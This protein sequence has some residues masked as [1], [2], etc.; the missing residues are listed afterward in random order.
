MRKITISTLLTL[1]YLAGTAQAL[2]A[3]QTTEDASLPAASVG[4]ERALTINEMRQQRGLTDTHN[5]F[6]PRGQWIFGGTASYSTHSN[7]T[8]RFLVVEGI[9]SK[10]YTF[11]VSPMI[12]YALRDNM[13]IGGRFIYSRSLLKLDKADLNL[14]GEDSDLNFEVNDYYSLRHSYSVAV[15]WRQYIPLGRNKRFALFNEMQLSGGG[16]QARFAKDSPVKGTYETGYTFSLG[17]SPGIV[18]FATNNMAVEVNVG[19]MGITYTH[20]KQ[21]HNQVTG[22]KRDASMMNFKVNIFSIGLG[23]A[24]YL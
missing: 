3:Q 21:V 15:I 2:R 5:L 8:Y 22:G 11:K 6:V 23:M 13:A 7:E 12:A 16:T 17:I 19:V 10:G 1:L 20:T 9:E 14:G 24:F 18:A 4:Q